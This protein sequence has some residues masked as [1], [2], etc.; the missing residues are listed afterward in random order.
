[1]RVLFALLPLILIQSAAAAERPYKV[2]QAFP[3]YSGELPLFLTAVPGTD[4]MAVVEQGGRVR[5]LAPDGRAQTVLDIGG[6]VRRV[7]NEE[8]LLGLAFHPGYPRHGRI[9]VYYS[10]SDPRRNVLS[11]W[12]VRNGRA[13]AERVLLDINKPYG[14]HNGGML[15]FGPDGFL[16]ISVGDG[17]SGGDPHG[18]AQNTA[19]L[20]GKIL[21]IDVDKSA[22]GR[23]YAIPP[24]NPF[25]KAPGARPEIWAY[26]LRNVWRFSFDRQ[27]GALWAGD[28]GQDAW[29][30]IDLV[31]RGGNYGWNLR[32]GKHVYKKGRTH[33]GP[34]IEPVLELPRSEAQS[35]TGGYVY[36]GDKFP[37][38]SGAYVFAD[39]M[40]GKIWSWRGGR[41]THIA[42]GE[43]ISSFG[44]DQNGELFYTSL[45]G[46]IY[47]LALP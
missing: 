25:A 46:K 32:E 34:A 3:A 8:G 6:K 13:E 18:N 21:R 16:Y 4:R 39:F 30:E 33:G 42:Q 28:V 45:D 27:T 10:A 43:L 9:Y 23:A 1:M 22:P 7:H 44:E 14:N 40:T 36:R 26:G 17:G 15:A 19:T 47:T 38:L 2:V 31:T 37:D 35:I 12:T 5:F 20:L 41:L 24:D 29:E 11:E